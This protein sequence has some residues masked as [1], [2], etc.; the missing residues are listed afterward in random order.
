[1][2]TPSQDFPPL[3]AHPKATLPKTPIT[4]ENLSATQIF[5]F[6]KYVRLLYQSIH[7]HGLN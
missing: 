6:D 7:A 5:H 3:G 2:H 1:M 4:P